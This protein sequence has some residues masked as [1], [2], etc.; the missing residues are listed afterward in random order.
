MNAQNSIETR[1][2]QMPKGLLGGIILIAIGLLSLAGQ[3]VQAEWYGQFILAALSALFLAGGLAARKPGLLVPGGIL[4]GISLGIWAQSLPMF[5]TETGE[6]G[7]FLLCF[8]AGWA[9]ITVLSLAIGRRLWW[10]LIPGGIMALIGGGLLVGG[11][12]LEALKWFGVFGWPL[13]LIGIGLY[14]IF[15]RK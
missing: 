6:A 10:P 3:F 4:G 13:L 8:A 9:L 15:R 1:V 2:K 12:A 7:I 11:F 14:V 5:E